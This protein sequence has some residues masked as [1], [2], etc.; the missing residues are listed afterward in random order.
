MARSTEAARSPAPHG[1]PRGFGVRLLQFVALVVGAVA[2]T[3][4]VAA[5]LGRVRGSQL[6]PTGSVAPAFHLVAEDGSSRELPAGRTTILEF[7]ETSCPHCQATA[8]VLCRLATTRPTIDI[9]LVDA[10][11]E[12]AAAL[13]AYRNKFFAHC[14]TVDRLA[15]LLD[16]GDRVT[17]L[18]RVTV[19]PTTY[20]VDA[21][22]RIVFAG[23]GEEATARA[24]AALAH[25]APGG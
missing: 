12:D 25:L 24:E 5:V 10:A 7:F 14:P 16:P 17:H 9:L 3:V 8:P 19:V 11:L 13:R 22:G 21:T 15:L 20:V 18:Y 2:T 1:R 4:L 6:L 23:V